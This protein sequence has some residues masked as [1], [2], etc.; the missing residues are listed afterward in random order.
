MRRF[1]IVSLCVLFSLSLS[2]QTWVRVNQVGFLPK[3][4][5]NAVL[6]STDEVEGD[7]EVC[8]ALTDEVVFRGKGESVGGSKWALKSG[9]RLDFSSLEREGGYYIVSN[10]VKSVTFRIAPDVYDGIADFLL[11]K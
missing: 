4:V 9:Y 7:F 5:K 10:G 8:D 3:D 6:I 11:I 1:F 2:A